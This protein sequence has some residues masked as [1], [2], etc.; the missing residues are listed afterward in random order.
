MSPSIR[1]L[2]RLWLALSLALMPLAPGWA[3]P[4]HAK[5]GDASPEVVAAAGCHHSA[6]GD[7]AATHKCCCDEGQGCDVQPGCGGHC[8]GIATPGVANTD[9]RQGATRVAMT[10]AADPLTQLPASS[11]EPAYRP[12][13]APSSAC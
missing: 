10:L 5:A 7:Q 4:G 3:A 13:I 12:P 11:F 9:T 6:T 2:A 8:G 1:F